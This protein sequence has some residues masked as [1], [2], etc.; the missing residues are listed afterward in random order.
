MNVYPA[1]SCALLTPSPCK[2]LTLTLC[3]RSI[4]W[5][6]G[7]R[8]LLLPLARLIC[9]CQQMTDR[10]P[11]GGGGAAASPGGRRISLSD[12]LYL[13]MVCFVSPKEP[14]EKPSRQVLAPGNGH[15]LH[16]GDGGGDTVSGGGSGV[17]V[18]NR[19]T[20]DSSRGDSA[21]PCPPTVASRDRRFFRSPSGTDGAGSNPSPAAAGR[22]G[23]FKGGDDLPWEPPSSDD[24]RETVVGGRSRTPQT[25]RDAGAP[26]KRVHAGEI[27]ASVRTSL[28]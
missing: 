18:Q 14:E 12:F 22:G 6:H 19:R 10:Y 20:P 27:S 26:T 28:F 1:F 8:L 17:R 3:I 24:D 4:R 21:T 15:H 9:I 2:V 25:R 23:A 7:R 16:H 11:G 13:A 5:P